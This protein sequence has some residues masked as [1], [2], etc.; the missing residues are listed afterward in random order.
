M[1]IKHDFEG[2]DVKKNIRINKK[3]EKRRE[4]KDYIQGGRCKIKMILIK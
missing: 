3:E 4:E 2:D 1:S